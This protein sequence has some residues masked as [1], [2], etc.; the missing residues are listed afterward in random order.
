MY[1]ALGWA[2][3]SPLHVWGPSGYTEEM[4]TAYFCDLMDKAALWHDQ[5]KLGV[6]PSGGMRIT[7]HEFDYS[8]FGPENPQLLV[9][10]DNDVQIYAFP[11]VHVIYGTVGYRLEWNRLAQGDS[12]SIS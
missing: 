7:P 4:G 2:R 6:V 11:V 9:Y 10:D 12:G 3:N 1:D 5:S 8:R